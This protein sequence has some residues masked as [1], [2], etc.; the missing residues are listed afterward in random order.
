MAQWLA[1]LRDK[2]RTPGPAL[3]LFT[4]GKKK[5]VTHGAKAE[6]LQSLRSL[7]SS[8]VLGSRAASAPKNDNVTIQTEALPPSFAR[9][10]SGRR[11]LAAE[12]RKNQ[13]PIAVCRLFVVDIPIGKRVA[14]LG[15]GVEH[16]AVRYRAAGKCL[17]EN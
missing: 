1:V 11:E 15:A 4:I 5:L 14:M 3:P 17:S 10:P 13:L 16:G 6:D 7:C 8:W 2:E 12:H 9:C